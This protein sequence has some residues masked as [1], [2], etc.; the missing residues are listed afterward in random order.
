MKQPFVYERLIEQWAE[1]KID[2]KRACAANIQRAS[3]SIN[4]I[5]LRARVRK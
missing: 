4:L 3:S 1:T 5:K 2:D